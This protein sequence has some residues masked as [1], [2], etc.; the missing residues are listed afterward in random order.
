MFLWKIMK[1]EMLEMFLFI[2]K[3]IYISERDTLKGFQNE[4]L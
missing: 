1:L 3:Q 2:L 4:L